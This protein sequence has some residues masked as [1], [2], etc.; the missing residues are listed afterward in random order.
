MIGTEGAHHLADAGPLH[1]DQP[2]GLVEQVII[3]GE[4][5]LRVKAAL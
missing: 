3:D 5:R 1:A 2:L 4:V